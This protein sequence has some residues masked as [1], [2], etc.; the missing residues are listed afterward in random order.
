MK[1]IFVLSFVFLLLGTAPLLA[2]KFGY[3]NSAALLSQM[4]EVKQA[5]SDLQ[6]FQT[7]LTKK[8]QQMVK[9]LQDKAASLE[10]RKEGGE[11]SPKQ[12]ETEM[13]ALQE[14]EKK[15]QE[16]EQKV[17][18]DI[19][20]KREELYKPILD[21]VNNAMKVVATKNQ[22]NMV[23]DLSTQVLLYADESLDVTKLVKA[24]LGITN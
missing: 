11:I 3:C 7:Q 19:S 8:G 15:I 1:K 4:P 2:Q 17:Y 12:Y 24:E 10:K 20:K 21:K 14:E 16:F 9:D 6:A 18:T 22:F 5:D 13:L 23:F